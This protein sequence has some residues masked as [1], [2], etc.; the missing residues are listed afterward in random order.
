M[1]AMEYAKY[2]RFQDN[3]YIL[4]WREL[5][6]PTGTVFFIDF[7]NKRETGKFVGIHGD[8]KIV[9]DPGG[10]FVQQ[11]TKHWYPRPFEPI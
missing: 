5:L 9:N 10:A 11:I 6:I 1:G 2:I 7:N 8:G 3:N 4:F